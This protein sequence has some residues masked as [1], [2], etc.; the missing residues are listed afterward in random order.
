[1]LSII[2]TYRT[3]ATHGLFQVYN[4]NSNNIACRVLGLVTCSSP[5]ISL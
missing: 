1:M 3:A 2:C 4:V 5:I